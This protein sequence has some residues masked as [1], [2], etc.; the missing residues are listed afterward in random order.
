MKTAAVRRSDPNLS[1][2]LD[3]HGAAKVPTVR[4]ASGEHGRSLFGAGAREAAFVGA[5][6]LVESVV[7]RRI[8]HDLAVRTVRHVERR[9]RAAADSQLALVASHGCGT[10][11]RRDL[12]LLHAR[13]TEFPH[14]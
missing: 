7:G 3:Q 13:G 1:D 2:L 9:T 8:Q 10:H 12:E 4:F 11:A 6:E 5:L 14:E